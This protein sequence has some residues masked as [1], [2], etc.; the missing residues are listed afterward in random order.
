M[1]HKILNGKKAAFHISPH[2]SMSMDCV[3]SLSET[4]SRGEPVCLH[5]HSG[6]SYLDQPAVLGSHFLQRRPESNQSPLS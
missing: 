6:P 5:L 4:C 3:F 2:C 1:S